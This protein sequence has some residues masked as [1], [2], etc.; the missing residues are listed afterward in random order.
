MAFAEHALKAIIVVLFA[1]LLILIGQIL[2][3]AIPAYRA[4]DEFPEREEQPIELPERVRRPTTPEAAE[5]V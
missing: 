1:V 3:V 5:T 2:E 4:G